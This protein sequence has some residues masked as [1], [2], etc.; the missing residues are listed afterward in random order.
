M[1]AALRSL[2]ETERS[3]IT[4][5]FMSGYSHREIA[6]FLEIPETTVQGRMRSG[7]KRLKERTIRMAEEDLGN[8]AP[9]R[10][11]RFADRIKRLVRPAELKSEDELPFGGGRGTDIWEMLTAAIRGDLATIERLVE[12]NPRLVE[13]GHQYRSPLHFAV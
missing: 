2:P 5:F 9:S 1:S 4:L 7:R 11:S 13:C 10:D 8:R 12:A 6:L 3:V